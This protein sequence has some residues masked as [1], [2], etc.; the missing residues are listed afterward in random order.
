MHFNKF[1]N[2]YLPT[3]I[4]VGRTLKFRE[5]NGASLPA[6]VPHHAVSEA[7]HQLL[8]T[9]RVHVTD[10]QILSQQTAFN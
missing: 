2:F 1:I 8:R 5:K 7:H 10:D 3:S 9:V 6:V 4:N